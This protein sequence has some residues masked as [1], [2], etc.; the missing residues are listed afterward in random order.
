VQFALAKRV[1]CMS[2]KSDVFDNTHGNNSSWN[3]SKRTSFRPECSAT[4]L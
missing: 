2:G 4:L 3:W 1:V